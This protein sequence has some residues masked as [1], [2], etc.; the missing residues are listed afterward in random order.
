[1]KYL[2]LGVLAHVDAGK[3][4]LCERLLY[5]NNSIKAFGRVDKNESF[6]DYDPLERKRGI[7]IF[8]KE[9][10]LQNGDK[11]ITLL[12]T[13]GHAD[14]VWETLS[15]MQVMDAALLI[16]DGASEISAF[17][18]RLYKLLKKNKIPTIIFL[19]KSDIE[20]N[21]QKTI[22]EKLIG[23]GANPI[24]FM[25]ANAWEEISLCRDDILENYLDR[26]NISEN[27]IKEIFLEGLFEPVFFGSALM[28]FGVDELNNALFS[29][30]SP[31]VKR[32]ENG[33]EKFTGE[34]LPYKIRYDKK[35]NRLV[36]GKVLK[37]FKIKDKINDDKIEEI[38]LYSGEKWTG[39]SEGIPGMLVALR[40][41]QDMKLHIDGD[42]TYAPLLEY[43]MV[44]PDTEDI[45]I[46]AEK[47][48][49]LGE[50]QPWLFMKYDSVSSKIHLSPM[51]EIQLEILKDIINER[52][53]VPVEFKK[54]GVKYKETIADTVEGVGHFEPLRHYAEVHLLLEPNPGGGIVI[55]SNTPVDML[56]ANWQGQIINVLKEIPVPGVLTRA[57]LT[58]IS[59]TLVA[60]KS[61]EKHTEGGDF[62]EATLRALRQGLMS[63]KNILLEPVYE[64][65]VQIPSAC[66][67]KLMVKLESMGAESNPPQY[68][69]EDIIVT[70]RFPVSK[71]EDFPVFVTS[72]TSGA[73]Y[74][75][76][77]FA[78]Y[79]PCEK[80][81]EIVENISYDPER[82]TEFPA[83]SVF[84]SHG[85]SDVVNWKDV[86]NRMHIPFVSG[87]AKISEDIT[88][89]PVIRE[90]GE[91]LIGIEEIESILNAAGGANKRRTKTDR[92]SHWNRYTRV[93]TDFSVKD[94]KTEKSSSEG[95]AVINTPERTKEYLLVD[96]YNIIFAW[97]DLKE[98]AEKNIDSAKDLLCDIMDEYAGFR[99]RQV[100]IVFDAYKVNGGVG[101]VTT[102][103]KIDVVY[104]KEAETADAYIERTA[105]NILE[106][107]KVYVATSD[108]LEQMIVRG[109]GAYVLS[110]SDL[111][112]EIR[113]MEE[114]IRAY[115]NSPNR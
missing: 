98:L 29:I 48:S 72:L 79:I 18:L 115:L 2:T 44:V 89:E 14:F 90:T 99:D 64:F 9:A 74:L 10:I 12:D 92:R 101:S 40:G 75:S 61:H 30:V 34:F 59:I 62:R 93:E 28:D 67:G 78:G 86:P 85:G 41:M 70:G 36:Y 1:M 83:E 46:F 113:L 73:G 56:A 60:G 107:H 104:T 102:W 31:R 26:G 42:G 39:I 23:A 97:T 84:T 114:E 50:E 71:L 8:S 108:R 15:C 19:N 6:L 58:D 87:G 80:Q 77:E 49:E 111:L 76:L 94:S 109:D 32:D 100:I 20:I 91:M 81:E 112:E 38:R 55:K 105:H 47:V 21:H 45:H 68:Q 65:E 37:S 52:Y 22:F 13:P 69:G 53:G 27:D 24:D 110:A 88:G 5:K 25:G 54:T 35:Q 95:K 7:T 57:P 17:T 103:G 63:V 82:D 4:T 11:S 66:L 96:G 16:V 106:K 43:E 3:T 51:G 33:T